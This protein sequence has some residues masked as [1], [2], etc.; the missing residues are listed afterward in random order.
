MN[1]ALVA[2]L[3][4]RFGR[5]KD[6][7]GLL[8]YLHNKSETKFVASYLNGLETGI[9]DLHFY[10]T[11]WRGI[12]TLDKHHR[13]AMQRVLGTEIDLQNILWIYRLKKY[14][15]ISGDTTYGYLVPV[16]YRLPADIFSRIIACK[17]ITTMQSELST[18]IY[19]NVFK[20]FTNAE[21]C[22]I[23]AVKARYLAESHKS[24]IALLCQYLYEVYR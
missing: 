20:N 2:K 4:A 14:Y 22:L 7:K 12:K 17:D 3:R 5:S 6:S 19:H 21:I 24:Y 1:A 23:N 10:L 16:R 8:R 18:T 13:I 11:L 9:R 15:G